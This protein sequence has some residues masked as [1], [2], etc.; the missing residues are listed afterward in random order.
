MPIIVPI[1]YKCNLACTYC[2]E[3]KKTTKID[4]NLSYPIIKELPDP[5]VFITGGEPLLLDDIFTICDTIRGFGKL[6]GLTTNGTIAKPEIANHVD[7]LGISL[8]GTREINDISRG[9]GNYDK[10][11]SFISSVVG[12]T[13]VGIMCTVG[14]WNKSDIGNLINVSESLGCDFIELTDVN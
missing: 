5:W 7:R 1:S 6:V 8:D 11:I 3:Y 9:V 2:R 12:K 4:I 13:E 10:A 14:E